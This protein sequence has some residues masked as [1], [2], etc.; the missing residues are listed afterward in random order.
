MDKDLRIFFRWLL[1]PLLLVSATIYFI[2]ISD[3]SLTFDG[4]VKDWLEGK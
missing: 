2:F 3:S 1:L 4:V